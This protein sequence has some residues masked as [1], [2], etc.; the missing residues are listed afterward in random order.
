MKKDDEINA[1][2][3]QIDAEKQTA[4]IAEVENDADHT[5]QLTDVQKAYL[6]PGDYIHYNAKTNK[7]EDIH[8]NDLDGIQV[9]T[10][11]N[12]I[13]VLKFMGKHT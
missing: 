2:V 5:V 8:E 13:V 7:I 11:G 9:K 3:L 12:A 6:E 10:T 1:V 4:E